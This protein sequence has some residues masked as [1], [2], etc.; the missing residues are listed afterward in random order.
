MMNRIIIVLLLCFAGTFAWAVP[1]ITDFTPVRGPI[2]QLVTL[3]GTEFLGATAVKFNGTSVTT[4]SVVT[5]ANVTTI[6]AVVPMGATTGK[7]SVIA[8]GGGVA[9]ATD[10][11]IE[12]VVVVIPIAVPLPPT[13]TGFTPANSKAGDSVT[14]TGTGFIGATAVNFNGT[15]ATFNILSATSI[16]VVVPAGVIT[17]KISVTTPNGIASSLADYVSRVAPTINLITPAIGPIGQVVTITGTSLLDV[18]AVRFNGTPAVSFKLVNE[19]SITAVVAAGTTTGKVTLVTPGGTASSEINFTVSTN[20]RDNATML[21]IPAATFTMGTE[22]GVVWWD[23]PHT[24]QV[25]LSGYWI[26]K[27]D[28]TVAQYLAFCAATGHALPPFPTGYSW[29]AEN[30]WKDDALQQHPIVNVTWDDANAYAAWAGVKLPTEAQWEYA[31]RGPAGNN[32][33]WGGTATVATPYDGWDDTKCANFNNSIKAKISTWPV[34][35]FSTGASWCGAQDMAGHVWQ[36]CGDWY[37][38]Y[39]EVPVTNPTGPTTGTSRVLR[40]GSWND[41]GTNDFGR[42]AYRYNGKPDEVSYN[43]G[44]RCVSTAPGP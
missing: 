44:F 19:T 41:D 37:D 27:Y 7:I 16:V 9:S 36:W 30:G 11:I 3:T 25:S 31:S 40:G 34:G 17:G 6:T 26:Y 13:I 12:T 10:F 15:G 4:F 29:A 2:G 5:V 28:I 39:S 32:Y 18:T 21:W 14:I 8:L 20:P 1:V 23:N 43:Y 38:V 42:G 24:Q 35:S 22:L 33:P